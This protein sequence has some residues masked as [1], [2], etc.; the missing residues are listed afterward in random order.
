MQDLVWTRSGGHSAKE[1]IDP[2]FFSKKIVAANLFS[3][4]QVKQLYELSQTEEI[5]NAMKSE[6]TELVE[7]EKAFGFVS[8]VSFFFLSATPPSPPTTRVCDSSD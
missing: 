1:A 6:A 8:S 5:K 4:D 7:K 2:Q 3:E